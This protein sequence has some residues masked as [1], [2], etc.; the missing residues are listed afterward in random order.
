MW[1]QKYAF[2]CFR[3][4]TTFNSASAV[5]QTAK[6]EEPINVVMGQNNRRFVGPGV[7]RLGQPRQLRLAQR[8]GRH[9]GLIQRIQQKPIGVRRLPDSDV[10]VRHRRSAGGK[11]RRIGKRRQQMLAVVVVAQHEV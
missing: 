5:D 4:I 11:R 6:P 2:T 7:E 3:G 8:S 10:L 1:P 9:I